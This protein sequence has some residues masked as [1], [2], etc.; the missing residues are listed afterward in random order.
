V[1]SDQAKS[2]APGVHANSPSVT[3]I[4]SVSVFL[5]SSQWV[6][7]LPTHIE[8]AASVEARRMR[9]RDSASAASMV[10]QRCGV[11]DRL[12]SSRKMRSAR[13]LYQGFPSD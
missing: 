8:R 10:G 9:K 6:T 2:A 12:V 5:C 11:A 13:R 4:K 3:A 7:S 1:A